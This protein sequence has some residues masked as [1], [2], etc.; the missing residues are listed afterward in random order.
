MGN[1]TET[2]EPLSYVHVQTLAFE[3]LERL[4][5]ALLYKSLHRLARR[6]LLRVAVV[7]DAAVLAQPGTVCWQNL[8]GSSWMKRVDLSEAN[9]AGTW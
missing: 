6:L 3:P 4:L 9:R 1:A 7:A 2:G 5:V 8:P